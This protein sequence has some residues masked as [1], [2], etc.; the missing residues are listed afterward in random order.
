MI[1]IDDVLER[2]ARWIVE[3]RLETP[4]VLLLEI[5]KPLSFVMGQSL[6]LS[7]PILA[8]IFGFEK[9]QKA[10]GLLSDHNSLE[11]LI[12]RIEKMSFEKR[13]GLNNA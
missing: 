8:P 6:Y 5:N 9:L 7:A 4:A 3:K 12:S 1:D 11:T 10:A 13:D 2:T